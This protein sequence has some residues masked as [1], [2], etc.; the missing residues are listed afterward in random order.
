MTAVSN[1]VTVTVAMASPASIPDTTD[2]SKVRVYPNPWRVDK[3]AG[4]GV[5][6]DQMTTEVTVR[7]F[8]VS[9]RCVRTLGPGTGEIA[10]DLRTGTGEMVA[11]GLY[12]YLLTDNQGGQTRGKLSVIR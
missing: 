3:H 4:H 1:T 12:L 7:I 10:W 5:T 9:G 6:F 8:T 11:S 2:L